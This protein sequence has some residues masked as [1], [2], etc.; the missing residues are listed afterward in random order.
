MSRKVRTAAFIALPAIALLLFGIGAG[1]AEDVN[2]RQPDGSTPLQWAVYD[3]DVA[4]VRRLIADGA[5]VSVAN[6]YGASPMSLAAEV[7]NTEIL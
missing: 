4:Q 1:G 5:D 3:E 2:A 7:A 6:N